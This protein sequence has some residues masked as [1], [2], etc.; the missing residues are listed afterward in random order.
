[1]TTIRIE[2]FR[3]RCIDCHEQFR[4]ESSGMSIADI[5]LSLRHGG[6]SPTWKRGPFDW[7]RADWFCGEC[8]AKRTG[9]RK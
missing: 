6:W 5:E 9:G 3:V 1:M 2:G 4:V 7:Q 8:Y